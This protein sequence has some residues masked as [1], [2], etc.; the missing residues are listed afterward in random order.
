M[1]NEISENTSESTPDAQLITEQ[2][3][4]V[5][6]KSGFWRFFLDVVETV[7]LSVLLFAGINAISAR[8]RVDGFS[9]EP[10]LQNGEFVIVNKLA[11][12]LGSPSHR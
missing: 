2:A 8:I 5:E 9:M 11:Y 6:K 7:V 4:P 1:D 10:T 3:V 12:K